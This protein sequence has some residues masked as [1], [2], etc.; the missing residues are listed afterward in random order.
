MKKCVPSQ[1]EFWRHAKV[2]IFPRGHMSIKFYPFIITVAVAVYSNRGCLPDKTLQ[3]SSQQKQWVL[4]QF[5][6]QFFLQS[7]S[8]NKEKYIKP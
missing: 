1:R 6:L 5:Q 2:S 8:L 4:F 3:Y 7:P